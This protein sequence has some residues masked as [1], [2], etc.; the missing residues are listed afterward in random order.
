MLFFLDDIADKPSEDSW[1]FGFGL[2]FGF[3]FGVCCP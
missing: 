1:G 3:A 2:G